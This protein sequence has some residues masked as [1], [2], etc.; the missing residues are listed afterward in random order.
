MAWCCTCTSA[1]RNMLL[2]VTCTREPLFEYLS[3]LPLCVLQPIQSSAQSPASTQQHLFMDLH[4]GVEGVNQ[5]CL[6][7]LDAYLRHAVVVSQHGRICE[8]D[9]LAVQRKWKYRAAPHSS[10]LR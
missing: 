1:L 8:G 6:S 4:Y 2:L 7:S 9:L 3:C 5:S 10:A